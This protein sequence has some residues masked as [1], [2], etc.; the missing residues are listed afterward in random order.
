MSNV[1]Q[2]YIPRALLRR[3]DKPFVIWAAPIPLA[4]FALLNVTFATLVA[5]SPD[6]GTIVVA[7]QTVSRPRY[8]M[9]VHPLAVTGAGITL[10]AAY[11]LLAERLWARRLLTV[12]L[13]VWAVIATAVISVGVGIRMTYLLLDSVEGWIILTVTFWYMYRYGP[14]RAYYVRLGM[15]DL[16]GHP[17]TR[18]R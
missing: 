6:A 12:W 5:A 16:P 3:R 18:Q 9:L 2:G 7:E 17:P 8:L 1:S 14:V 13:A 15:R 4:A 11:G 10:C